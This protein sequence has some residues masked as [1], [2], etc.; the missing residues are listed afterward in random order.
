M[1]LRFDIHVHTNRYS[2]CS[3]ID[4]A[5]LIGRAVKA[6]LDGV[7]ITE[8]EHQWDDAELTALVDASGVPGFVLLAGFEYTSVQGDL[9]VYGLAPD[10]VALFEPGWSPE[11]A[12]DQATRLGGVCIAAHPTR[13]GLGFDE[14]IYGLPLAGIEVSSVN[15]QPHE[16]RLAMQVAENAQ[17]PPAASSDAHLLSQVGRYAMVFDEVIRSMPG[18]HDALKHGRFRID[19]D[20]FSAGLKARGT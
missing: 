14:R 7:V 8:H 17:I 4:P 20:T 15:L 16:Q 18:L 13:T 5:K 1:A 11:M 19:S 9:L 6:G 3:R 10:Q 12:V 2:P